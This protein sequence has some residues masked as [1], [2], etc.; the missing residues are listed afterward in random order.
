MSYMS[1][2]SNDK[3][4]DNLVTGHK[5]FLVCYFFILV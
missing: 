1:Y 3:V 4:M 5:V 2:M